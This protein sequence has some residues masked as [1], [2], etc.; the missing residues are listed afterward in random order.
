VG[1]DLSL[2]RAT[3]ADVAAVLGLLT[4]GA[5]Y[6][7]SHG[8][9][10]WPD[11]FADEVLHGDIERGELYVGLVDD[12]V[13]ATLTYTFVDVAVW[14][15]DDGR[16]SYVHRLAVSAERRGSGLGAQ[17]LAWAGETGLDRGRALLRLDTLH[18]NA[19]LR[20]WYEGSGFIHVRDRDIDVPPGAASR[21]Q[22]RV[23]LYERPVPSSSEAGDRMG[24]REELAR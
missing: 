9:D 16:A 15:P 2:R 22:L 19:R 24:Q 3:E 18:E 12:A 14:G 4:A 23:S 17:L 13:V 1:S 8:V 7:Q 20:A 6:A 10:M 11:R 5:R 21:P